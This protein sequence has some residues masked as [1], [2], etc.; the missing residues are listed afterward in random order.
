MVATAD[1]CGQSLR[2]LPLRSVCR[3]RADRYRL[4][5]V[6]EKRHVE[7]KRQQGELQAV[8]FAV[9]FS[10]LFEFLPTQRKSKTRRS[11]LWFCHAAGP[12]VRSYVSTENCMLS[13]PASRCWWHATAIGAQDAQRLEGWNMSCMRAA[14]L[15]HRLCLDDLAVHMIR[16]K[17]SIP[18]NNNL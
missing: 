16:W 7:H 18:P 8:S 10:L 4:I 6:G 5:N 13:F 12:I 2:S 1:A 11:P 9:L 3:T 17:A 15:T 14:H